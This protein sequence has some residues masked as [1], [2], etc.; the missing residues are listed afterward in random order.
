M[1]EIEA[2]RC[3]GRHPE[4]RNRPCNA[5]L[6]DAVPGT[7]DVREESTPP[8]GEVLVKCKRC[9]TTYLPVRRATAY[10]G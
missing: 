8:P 2:I 6:F 4:D 9:G 1:R 5:R 10:I 3:P 7:V